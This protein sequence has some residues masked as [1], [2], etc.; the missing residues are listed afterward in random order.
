MCFDV[1]S[2]LRLQTAA[3]NA[4]YPK[5]KAKYGIAPILIQMSDDEGSSE[6]LKITP[7]RTHNTKRSVA[8]M[9][10]TRVSDLVFTTDLS[11]PSYLAYS[12]KQADTRVSETLFSAL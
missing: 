5:V 2:F 11:I 3:R 8:G 6:A 9:R 10:L 12:K 4:G 1:L 7:T